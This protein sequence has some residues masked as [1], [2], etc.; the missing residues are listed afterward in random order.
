MDPLQQQTKSGCVIVRDKRTKK[1]DHDCKQ[2]K[3]AK[4]K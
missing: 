1:D 4:T 2:N 3:N